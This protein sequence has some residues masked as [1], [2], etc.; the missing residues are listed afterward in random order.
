MTTP[1]RLVGPLITNEV[2]EEL[3]IERL[4]RGA[5]R[6]TTPC[7]E[8]EIEPL[9]AK[10]NATGLTESALTDAD[11]TE[12]IKDQL[13]QKE[14][15]ADYLPEMYAALEAEMHRVQDL[16]KM[17]RDSKTVTS[18]LRHDIRF[19]HEDRVRFMWGS[20]RGGQVEGTRGLKMALDLGQDALDVYVL[21]AARRGRKDRW[22]AKAPRQG[23]GE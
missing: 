5:L 1:V 19:K 21:G 7:P 13:R 8:K 2:S 14:K 9:T 20:D 12:I 11:H 18:R 22:T 4:R 23:I 3:A 17:V 6:Q 16:E 10:D 15:Q